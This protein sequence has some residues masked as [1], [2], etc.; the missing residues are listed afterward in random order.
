MPEAGA[1][2][3][4]WSFRWVAVAALMLASPRASAADLLARA[5]TRF[6]EGVRASAAGRF[7][8]AAAAFRDAYRLSGRAGS[9]FNTAKAHEAAGRPLLAYA[10]YRCFLD[11]SP[12]TPRRAEVEGAMRT[13]GAAGANDSAPCN[14]GAPFDGRR[15]ATAEA[16]VRALAPGLAQTAAPPPEVRATA[17]GYVAAAR[18]LCNR[19]ASDGLSPADLEYRAV[20][21]ELRV[22]RLARFLTRHPPPPPA[23]AERTAWLETLFDLAADAPLAAVS[24]RIEVLRPGGERLPDGAELRSGEQFRL[25]V[26]VS[27]PSHVYV[28]W[29]DGRGRLTRLHPARLTG[30]EGTVEGQVRIPADPGRLFTLDREAGDERIWLFA[31]PGPSRAIEQLLVEV[32]EGPGASA[33]PAAAL[34]SAVGFKGVFVS[35]PE[36]PAGPSVSALGP[37]AAVFR[38]RH[39]P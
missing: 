35:E 4:I 30:G 24:T 3:T 2:P 20:A 15:H 17:E 11:E 28:V 5:R 1:T 16:L 23:A 10:F 13:L 22:D 31:L 14:P 25:L 26:G 7:E 36:A 19:A 21:L 12:D 6:D 18:A 9:L 39:L 8:T 38:I 27:R 37:A 34:A 29:E 32:G 33:A